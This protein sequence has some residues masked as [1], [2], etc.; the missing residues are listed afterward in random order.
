MKTY[1]IEEATKTGFA[2]VLKEACGDET[3]AL[4]DGEL[5]VVLTPLEQDK[6]MYSPEWYSD[7][8]IALQNVFATESARNSQA[9]VR[10]MLAE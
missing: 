2:A 5:K 8:D 3:V 9:A 6:V 4:V 1:T 7:D 10:A